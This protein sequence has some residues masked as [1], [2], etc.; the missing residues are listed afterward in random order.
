[1][2]FMIVLVAIAGIFV[3]IAGAG[4]GFISVSPAIHSGRPV[5]GTKSVPVNRT[6][7][8]VGLIVIAVGIAILGA[9]WL[10][11]QVGYMSDANV[12]ARQAESRVVQAN[13]A[14]FARLRDARDAV[15]ARLKDPDSAQFRNQ[16]GWCGEVNAKNS[17]GGYVGYRRFIAS[18]RTVLVEGDVSGVVFNDT[19][20]KIC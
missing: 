19:W 18:G 20:R 17:L 12:A 9:D 5:A 13:V 4:V 14:R 6:D 10:W 16:A 8:Q 1:M 7:V 3:I 15:R 11:Y 2:F